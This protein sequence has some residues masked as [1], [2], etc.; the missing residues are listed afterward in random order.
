M[1]GEVFGMNSMGTKGK[2]ITKE[3]TINEVIKRYPDT[4]RVFHKY[5]VDSCCGGA[6]SIEKSVAAGGINLEKLIRE[7]NEAVS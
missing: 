7:L 2:S 6:E 5:N 1:R 3:M 4:M